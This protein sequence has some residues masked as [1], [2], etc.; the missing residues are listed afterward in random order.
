V[1]GQAF[2]DGTPEERRFW[3]TAGRIWVDMGGVWGGN[4]TSFT[5]RPHCEFTD[6]LTL[7][8]L[9]GGDKVADYAVMPWEAKMPH[10][11]QTEVSPVAL[12]AEWAADAR[13]WA[14]EAEL[15]DGTRPLD[16]LTRQEAW[17]LLYRFSKAFG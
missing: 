15:S 10:A 11:A 4:W 6:G 9:Q 12:V 8:Q 13:D 14:L 16:P 7:R 3:D 17:T 5:D 1:Q 2:A